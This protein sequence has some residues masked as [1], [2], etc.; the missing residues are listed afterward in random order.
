[1]ESMMES[2][3]ELSNKE[4]ETLNKIVAFK[5]EE[6]KRIASSLIETKRE[7]KTTKDHLIHSS[8]N[9][10]TKAPT[11]PRKRLRQPLSNL[12]YNTIPTHLGSPNKKLTSLEIK[13]DSLE[14]QMRLITNKLTT[15]NEL[16]ETS[17]EKIAHLETEIQSMRELN[18]DLESQIAHLK[19]SGDM[20]KLNWDQERQ[21]LIQNQHDL[22]ERLHSWSTIIEKSV[23]ENLTLKK[24][25]DKLEKIARLVKLKEGGGALSAFKTPA[26]V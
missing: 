22:Q 25:C 18:H 5:D 6:N 1:M 13:N 16:Y 11:S 23:E 19:K 9:S 12:D 21:V 3:I 4:I 2:Q 20:L 14:S 15:T 26:L 17:I 10:I 8:L 24:K 7:L